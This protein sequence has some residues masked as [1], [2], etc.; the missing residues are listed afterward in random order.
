LSSFLIS[1]IIIYDLLQYFF[2]YRKMDASPYARE[3]TKGQAPNPR[4]KN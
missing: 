3:S 1:R 2:F 4:D